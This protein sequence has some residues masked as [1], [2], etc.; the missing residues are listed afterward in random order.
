M[1]SNRFY[2]SENSIRRLS[3]TCK[4]IIE[5]KPILTMPLELVEIFRFFF[6]NTFFIIV[7]SSSLRL[8]RPCLSAARARGRLLGLLGR[9]SA[10]IGLGR[11]RESNPRD[12]TNVLASPTRIV[13]RDFFCYSLECSVEGPEDVAVNV[14]KMR[15]VLHSRPDLTGTHLHRRHQKLIESRLEVEVAAERGLHRLED[16]LYEQGLRCLDFW[17]IKRSV[18]CKMPNLL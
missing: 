9:F 13:R 11:W 8:L 3:E 17:N 5:R 14:T 7:L 6:R 16:L 2:K 12:S 4:E 15:R 10:S 18:I 1:E